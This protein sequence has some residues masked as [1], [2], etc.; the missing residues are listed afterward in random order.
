MNSAMIK[1]NRKK[2]KQSKREIF[3]FF[4]LTQRCWL[5]KISREY[6]SPILAAII[7]KKPSL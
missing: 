7:K 4:R 5:K 6:H 1:H 3:L 2:N